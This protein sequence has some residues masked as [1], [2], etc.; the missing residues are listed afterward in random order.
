MQLDDTEE[1][2]YFDALDNVPHYYN[3]RAPSA[4]PAPILLAPRGPLVSSAPVLHM[5]SSLMVP[6]LPPFDH[7]PT[8]VMWDE[9]VRVDIKCLH[10]CLLFHW[11]SEAINH[12]NSARHLQMVDFLNGEPM[13]YCVVCNWLPDMPNLHLMGSRHLKN[14]R[15][16]GRIAQHTDMQVR[17]VHLLADGRKYALLVNPYD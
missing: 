17:R 1:A 8:L 10:C 13:M 9:D 6:R 15:R 5:D 14:L 16:V 2:N 3:D 11:T 12:W 4:S 7:Q